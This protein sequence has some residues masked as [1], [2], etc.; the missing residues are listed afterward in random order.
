MSNERGN[1]GGAVGDDSDDYVFI[2]S[3]QIILGLSGGTSVSAVFPDP[4]TVATLLRVP[5][6]VQHRRVRDRTPTPA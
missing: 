4:E 2:D 5:R 6:P 1:D 3:R